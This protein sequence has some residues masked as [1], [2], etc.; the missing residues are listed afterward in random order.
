MIIR[1]VWKKIS[2]FGERFSSVKTEIGT[3]SAQGLRLE[4]GSV[5]EKAN[6]SAGRPTDQ[7]TDGYE[8]SLG[9]KL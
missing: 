7:P 2:R 4:H 5:Y 6:R 9:V 3:E 8:S 1:Y